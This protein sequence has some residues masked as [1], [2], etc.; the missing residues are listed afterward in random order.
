MLEN[1]AFA[2]AN[3]VQATAQSLESLPRL[4]AGFLRYTPARVLPACMPATSA[5]RAATRLS[6][7]VP[8][9]APSLTGWFL[10]GRLEA[11][12]PNHHSRTLI[13]SPLLSRMF[14]LHVTLDVGKV[15]VAVGTDAGLNPV[16]GL[17]KLALR[18]SVFLTLVAKVILHPSRPLLL[19]I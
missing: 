2:N 10:V 7:I 12:K 18:H 1:G 6:M 4:W 16:A 3:Q 11:A 19:R 5:P 14:R 13:S 8:I 17:R 15:P 9:I